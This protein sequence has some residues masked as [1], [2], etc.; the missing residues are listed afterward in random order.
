MNHKQLEYFQ[1]VYNKHSVSAAAKTF[2]ISPQGLSKMIISLEKELNVTLFERS[3]K[4]MIPT[5]AAISLYSHVKHILDEYDLILNNQFMTFE[6]KKDL[7]IAISYDAMSYFPASFFSNFYTTHPD[8][9]L[10]FI[11]LP[12][13]EALNQLDSNKVELAVLPGPLHEGTYHLDPLFS[14]QFCFLFHKDNPLAHKEDFH[15]ADTQGES[16]V[17]KSQELFFSDAQRNHLLSLG[18]STNIVMECTDLN[19]ITKLV[20]NNLCIGMIP[21]YLSQLA[22]SINIITRH[23]M[24][25]TQEKN[26]YLVHRADSVLSQESKEFLLYCREYV[27][28]KN[29]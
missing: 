27:S 13:S 5:P 8:I 24:D 14:H 18:I 11:E 28:Q 3:E 7:N 25:D 1:E 22:T 20:E 6:S 29:L 9:L 15:L 19:V 2:F 17:I 26:M 12:D 16:I 23:P 10:H 21:E 4:K